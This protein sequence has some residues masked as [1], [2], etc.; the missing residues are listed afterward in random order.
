MIEFQK[1]G[2]P[3][4]HLIIAVE[5]EIPVE[6][7]DFYVSAEM[8]RDGPDLERRRKL[9]RRFMTHDHN[10]RCGGSDEECCYHFPFDI[11]EETYVNDQN[12]IAYR[13]R[14]PEDA[15]IVAHNVALLEEFNYH[16]NVEKIGNAEVYGYL[17]KYFWKGEIN[18]Y[19]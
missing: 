15:R 19:R 8:P 13:R 1:R 11:N 4:A 10:S 17:F 7:I 9:V 2:L 12:R 5:P 16:I 6:G 14:H 3:H 18:P